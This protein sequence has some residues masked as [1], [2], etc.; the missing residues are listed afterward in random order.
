MIN[1]HEAKFEEVVNSRGE[2]IERLKLR[3]MNRTAPTS[4]IGRR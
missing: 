2:H 4:S 1:I 3:G